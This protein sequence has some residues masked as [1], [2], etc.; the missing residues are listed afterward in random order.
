MTEPT[1]KF[2][3]ALLWVGV[4]SISYG[5]GAKYGGVVRHCFECGGQSEYAGVDGIL[6]AYRKVFDS[7]LIMSRPTV[8]VEVIETVASRAKRTQQAATRN[9]KQAYTVLLILTDGAVSDIE[10]T[11]ACLQRVS[12]APLSIV[13]I[14]VGNADFTAMQF[15]DDLKGMKRDIVQ[16]VPFNKY[17]YDSSGLTAATLSA[18]PEQLTG[19]FQCMG[20]S[21]HPPIQLRPS[22]D[23]AVDEEETE[24]DLA[25]DIQEDRI[26]VTSGGVDFV[27]GFAKRRR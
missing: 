21:P 1:L 24:V 4:I 25:L 7:G 23:M 27:D 10:A 20:I 14:G 13:I 18:I 6:N 2:P 16:F 11:A 15:L 26:V 19:Y 22:D 8:L 3:T 9:D 17:R 5:F 12:D